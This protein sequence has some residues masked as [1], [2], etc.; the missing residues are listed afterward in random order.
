MT[1]KEKSNTEIAP[2]LAKIEELSL[3]ELACEVSL[4]IVNIK[5]QQLCNLQCGDSLALIL[6]E[7]Q[8]VK[9]FLEGQLLAC[10]ILLSDGE[11]IWVKIKETEETI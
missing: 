1:T 2:L 9:I 7:A 3:K 10:G 4:G 6:H 5:I 8:E 11:K